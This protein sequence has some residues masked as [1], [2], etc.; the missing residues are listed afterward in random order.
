[1]TGI[2]ILHE[3]DVDSFAFSKKMQDDANITAN[4]TVSIFEPLDTKKKSVT[5]LLNGLPQGLKALATASP[6]LKKIT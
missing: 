3:D 5:N 4:S 6:E 2:H 1:M